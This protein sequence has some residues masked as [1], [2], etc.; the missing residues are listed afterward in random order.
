[1]HRVP[2]HY[3]QAGR[4]AIRAEAAEAHRL[5]RSQPEPLQPGPPARS[6]KAEPTVTLTPL[7]FDA[8]SANELRPASFAQMVGQDRLRRLVGRI[9]TNCRTNHRPLDHLMLVGQSG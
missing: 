2:Q 8:R 5:S 3:A 6:R 9:V 4:L 1:M 7:S